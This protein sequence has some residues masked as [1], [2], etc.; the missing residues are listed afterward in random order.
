MGTSRGLS[1]AL[2]DFRIYNTL[3]YGIL[4]GGIN[5]L[6]TGHSFRDHRSEHIVGLVLRS[7]VHKFEVNRSE[8]FLN[9][10]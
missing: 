2:D 5:H 4:S 8:I 1:N 3:K 10:K 6:D 7:L 9:S